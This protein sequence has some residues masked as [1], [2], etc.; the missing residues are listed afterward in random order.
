MRNETN[1]ESINERMIESEISK[2][3]LGP[4]TRPYYQSVGQEELV[5]KLAHKEKLPVLLKGPTG[6]G[7][8]RF[9][10]AMAFDLQVPLVTNVDASVITSGAEA[11]EALVRQVTQPV[12]WLESVEFLISQGVQSFVEIGPGKVLSGLVRQIDRNVRCVNVEDE[13]SL[14]A[15][16]AA[17]AA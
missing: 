5:F 6:C 1:S 2:V 4:K 8:S 7:K 16:G 17:L 10:D 11:R 15:A 9:V 3:A 12:R 14:R 13:E